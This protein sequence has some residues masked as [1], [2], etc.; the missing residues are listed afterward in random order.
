MASHLVTL[1]TAIILIVLAT[2]LETVERREKFPFVSGVA[3]IVL[4]SGL[5]GLGVIPA[6]P[7][8]YLALV[9]VVLVLWSTVPLLRQSP[10][11]S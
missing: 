4:G 8:G 7:G 11:T 10:T 2:V 5:A 1:G 3:L 9:G 6:V